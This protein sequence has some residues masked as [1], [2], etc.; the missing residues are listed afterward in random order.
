ME[1]LIALRQ[2]A[3]ETSGE[4]ASLEVSGAAVEHTVDGMVR[5]ASDAWPR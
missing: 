5:S 4:A 1:T 2:C 3:P